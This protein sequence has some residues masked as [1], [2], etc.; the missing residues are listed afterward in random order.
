MAM[1]I[2]CP[3][4]SSTDTRLWWQDERKHMNE[5]EYWD[6]SQC[7][8]I[9]VPPAFHLTTQAEQAFY[10]LHENN[11]EDQRYRQFLARTFIPMVERL[12]ARAEGLDFGSG[13]GPTLHIMFEEAGFPCDIYDPYF[14]PNQS[15]WERSYSFITSTEVFEHV[16]S[17]KTELERLN[18]VLR[19]DGLLAIMTQRP[20]SKA[21]FARWRYSMDPTHICFFREATFTWIA[22]YYR[23]QID[24]S[25]K[26]V[27]IFRKA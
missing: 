21:A 4:C 3:L 23:W 25:S 12:P 17:P 7:Q 6:C 22:N 11:P 24:Y 5:R 26:D 20:E 19:R 15:V 16:H 10:N 14:A 8:L 1:V 27:I 9:F 18:N 13:P 2:N